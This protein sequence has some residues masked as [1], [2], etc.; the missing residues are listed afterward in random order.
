M[1]KRLSFTT[2]ADTSIELDVPDE[3]AI[4]GDEA[5]GPEDLEAR[6]LTGRGC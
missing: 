4:M 2:F 5:I 6:C 3:V 1:R